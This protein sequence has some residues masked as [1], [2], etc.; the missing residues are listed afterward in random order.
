MFYY[1]EHELFLIYFLQKTKVI[2]WEL[3]F[4]KE[5]IESHFLGD[6]NWD[7]FA[8]VYDSVDKSKMTLRR[9]DD[10][11]KLKSNFHTLISF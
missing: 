3:K 2:S 5:K 4:D 1:N 11:K 7:F 9:L 6:E 10:F 8:E